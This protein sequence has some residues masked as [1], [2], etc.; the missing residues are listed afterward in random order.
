MQIFDHA[1]FQT[2][3][4]TI[5]GITSLNTYYLI[6]AQRFDGEYNSMIQASLVKGIFWLNDKTKN[7]FVRT[8]NNVF[9]TRIG[10][11]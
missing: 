9:K 2:D 5:V 8:G 7:N 10:Y 11:K 6:T 1:C 3:Y 4:I